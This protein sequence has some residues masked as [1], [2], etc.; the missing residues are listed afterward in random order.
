MCSRELEL[1]IIE[2]V[3]LFPVAE[4]SRAGRLPVGSQIYLQ[5]ENLMSMGMQRGFSTLHNGMVES[6]GMC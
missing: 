6:M 2:E 5:G 1:V 3:L 4:S